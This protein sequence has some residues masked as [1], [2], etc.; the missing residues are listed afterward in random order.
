MYLSPDDKVVNRSKVALTSSQNETDL[1]VKTLSDT[2]TDSSL[3]VNVL[4]SSG[5]GKVDTIW[6]IYLY[7]YVNSISKL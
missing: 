3:L 4:V 5:A 2:E 7:T 1:T 6:H